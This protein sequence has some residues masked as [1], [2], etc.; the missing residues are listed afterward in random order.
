MVN[1]HVEGSLMAVQLCGSDEIQSNQGQAV[2]TPSWPKNEGAE[3]QTTVQCL[4]I[5]GP[6]ADRLKHSTRNK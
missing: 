5:A 1:V 2:W 4:G 6:G 3:R